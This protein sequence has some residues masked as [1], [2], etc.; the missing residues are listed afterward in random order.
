[1]AQVVRD[2]RSEDLEQIKRIHAESGIDYRFPNLESPL[3]I[4]KKTLEVDGR[5]RAAGQLYLQ[6]EAYL[7]IDKSQWASP[8]EKMEAIVALDAAATDE[9]WLKGLSQ[10]VLWLPPGMKRFGDRLAAMGYTKDRE[11]TTFS[12][13]ILPRL[14]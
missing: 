1:M 5:V 7:Q 9:A 2:Y 12:K 10:V 13:P 6:C 8:V 11:W 14:F 3:F 4:V